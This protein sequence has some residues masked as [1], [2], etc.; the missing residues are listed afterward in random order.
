MNGVQYQSQSI[1]NLLAR[2]WLHINVRHRIRFF[3][4][5]A[6]M[7]GASFAEVL[8]IGAVV[9]FLLVLTSPEKIFETEIAQPLIQFF[10]ISSPP[11]LLLPL[12]I[13][14][15]ISVILA[16]GIRL[17]L[18]WTS[19]RLSFAVGADLSS[20]IY[21]RMLYQPYSVHI[22]QNSSV[23]I[24]GVSSK[25]DGVVYAIIIPVLT[26]ISSIIILIFILTALFYI[27]PIIALITFVGFGSM[28]AY[29]V[30]VTRK[31][32]LINSHRIANHSTDVIKSLQEGLGGIRDILLDGSQEVY[33][34]IYRK[35]DKPL[36]KAQGSN[37]FIGQSPRYGVE[38]LGMI[39][40]ASLAYILA[41]GPGGISV[42]IATLGALA[43]GAQRLLPVLQQAYGAWTSI[44]SGQ[45]SLLDVLDLLDQP[46]PLF[47]N[48]PNTT[49]LVF[50]NCITL[51]EVS[52][53]Y[54]PLSPLILSDINIEI[55]KGS[56]VGLIG[57]T[58]TGKSTLL[59]IVMGLLTPLEGALMIDGKKIS[60]LNNRLWQA[61][62][63]HV[64]QA[65]F[66]TDGTIA[67]NIAFGIP[68]QE[69]DYAR[70]ENAA[71]SA[72]ISEVIKGWPEGYQ[73]RVGER[74]VRLS[75][76]Q[77]Q[78]LGIARALYKKADVIIFDEATSALDSET[79]C[80][81]IEA[82]EGLGQDITI[83]IIAHRITTLKNC[84]QIVELSNGN[85][86][87]IGKYQ[88]IV[89]QSA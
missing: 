37:L 22:A 7:L 74:G 73:T 33:C 30:K 89:N 83:I 11:Q 63:A 32:L 20:G 70:V 49:P 23:L 64:P 3:G 88:D 76:G 41:K 72:Q 66:L 1:F 4:L 15:G 51:K 69:I 50:K 68:K 87:R 71:R 27:D 16:A 31:Q 53:R 44:Q 82:I 46:L 34:D 38:A 55:K 14:F 75:G 81:V 54:H 40:I 42:T 10:G 19:T 36:R 26:L 13:T 17:I 8:T 61:H 52:F 6:L 80:A 86:K 60:P 29:I 79:E 48:Q 67:E 12:T 24:N 58:G 43:L 57:K 47:I 56:R 39:L 25:A 62:I 78:R 28:Y 18:L 21:R 35:A 5:L 85:I 9:P 2:L 59:D 84:S 65:I 77:R 45:A